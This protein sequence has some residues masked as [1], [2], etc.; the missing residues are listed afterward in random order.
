[1]TETQ[2]EQPDNTIPAPAP[3]TT[4]PIALP[5]RE[6]A[7]RPGF[8]N[9]LDMESN[10]ANNILYLSPGEREHYI[11]HNC[12]MMIAAWSCVLAKAY[13]EFT[14]RRTMANNLTTLQRQTRQNQYET[15]VFTTKLQI[16]SQRE[17][18]PRI[19]TIIRV[20]GMA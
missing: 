13:N 1:M 3:A 9:N 8:P 16:Q 10:K 15:G 14:R 17:Q 12:S 11:C 19:L 18:D 2:P 4:A 20:I 6:P 7:W 5:Q